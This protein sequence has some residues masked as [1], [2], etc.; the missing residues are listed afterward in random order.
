L[1][2]WPEPPADGGPL[3]FA[4]RGATEVAPE[5]TLGA[6]LSSLR[7]AVDGVECDVR[8]TR[9]GHLVCVHD[10]RLERT[11][12]GI[13]KVST[14]TLGDLERLD[15]GPGY[16]AQGPRSRAGSRPGRATAPGPAGTRPGGP[17]APPEDLESPRVEVPDLVDAG[18]RRI[19]TLERLV[20]AVVDAGRPVKLLVETK[21]PTRYGNLVELRL[22]ELLRRFGL[23]RPKPDAAVQVAVMSFSLLALRRLRRMAPEVPTVLLLEYLPPGLLSGARPPFGA[24]A[25][26]PGV[27]VL[28]SRPSLVPRLR[29]RGVPVFVWTVNEPA[30]LDLVLELGVDGIITDRPSTVLSRLGR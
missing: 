18:H 11:S 1:A 19:L 27:R 8:L 10:R 26:G 21:H 7:S 5:H 14:H 6:Y 16:P 15:F 12:D 3:V 13:G 9:D 2:T 22:L 17:P 4:H 29:E 28:R 25:V 23:D 24:S 20:E 30:D